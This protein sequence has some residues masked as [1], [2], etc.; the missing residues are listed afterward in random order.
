M[1][2]RFLLFTSLAVAA[3]CGQSPEVGCVDCSPIQ[4]ELLTT[5]GTEDGPGALS[6]DPGAIARDA[7]GRFYVVT[8][9]M[10]EELPFVYD[11]HGTLAHKPRCLRPARS[12]T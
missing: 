10:G 2:T 8:P 4:L 9:Y 6:S 11:S 7:E 1:I 3:A 12:Y 5:L